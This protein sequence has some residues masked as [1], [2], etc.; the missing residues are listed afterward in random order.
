MLGR[1]NGVYEVLRKLAKKTRVDADLFAIYGV[2]RRRRGN[3]DGAANEL[4][5]EE[6]VGLWLNLKR[7]EAQ[8]VL[9]MTK[10]IGLALGADPDD[11][12]QT[13]LA[14]G[15]NKEQV[16]STVNGLLR[17]QAMQKLGR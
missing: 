12:G 14:A 9:V 15:I 1:S 16:T 6:R 17:S 8:K 4:T 5:D 11:L 3:G 10:A 7:I 2:T 13:M